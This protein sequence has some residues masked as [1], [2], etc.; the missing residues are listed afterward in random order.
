MNRLKKIGLSALAGSLA[1]V[2]ANAAEYAVTGD[3]Y[4]SYQSEDSVK[5][6]AGSGKNFSADMDLY[7]TASTELDNGFDIT[8][9][10]AV[11][12]DS[13]LAVTSM[14]VTL[15][16]GSLGTLQLNEHGGSKANGIDDVMP[17]AMQ[18]T[19]DRVDD[20][21]SSDPSFFGSSTAS[22]SV[23]YR[24]PTQEFAGTTINASITYDPNSGEAAANATS[25]GIATNVPGTAY[26]LQVSNSGLEIGGGIE[27]L[28]DDQGLAKAS[29]TENTTVYAKYS[30]GPLTVGYQE[31]YKNARNA[32]AS[33]PGADTEVEMWGAAYTVNDI[34]LS[35]AETEMQVKG[36][37]A[38]A[39][40]SV[41]QWDSLQAA[42]SMGAMTISAALSEGSNV[43]GT[44]G[45][46]YEETSVAVNFAF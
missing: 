6:E 46:N 30:Y 20:V 23:D 14:Q 36:V 1:A 38:T 39:A 15:G 31:A 5:S 16:M 2:S 13:T 44:A 4:V 12:T 41:Q 45:A 3:A 25:G 19:W 27:M 18:E 11:N 7:F 8:F 26:T 9:F 24:I 10:Q 37:G 28:D 29:G 43:A 42:Y 34:T 17:N 22:G 40:G 33:L 21:N 35:Y 32:V